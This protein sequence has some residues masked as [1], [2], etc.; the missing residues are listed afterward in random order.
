MKW[1]QIAIIVIISASVALFIQKMIAPEA[2]VATGLQ[3]TAL[4]RITKNGVLRCGYIP[5]KPMA[6][7]DPATGAMSGFA[8]DFMNE[9][10][11]KSNLKI[12]WTTELTHT[13]WFQAIKGG[14]IDA[15][16]T[17]IWPHVSLYKEIKFTRPLMWDDL[18]PV[19]RASDPRFDGSNISIDTNVLTIAVKQ[20]DSTAQ[21][22][23]TVLPKAKFAIYAMETT[24]DALYKLLMDREFDVVLRDRNSANQFAQQNLGTVRILLDKGNIGRIAYEMAVDIK[25]TELVDLFNRF[26]K[27][28]QGNKGIEQLLNKWYG[29][30]GVPSY[31]PGPM[32]LEPYFPFTVLDVGLPKPW[33][34][35]QSK[36]Q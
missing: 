35:D 6:M 14:Q 26:I 3:D 12:E 15:L 21:L 20:G 34:R 7:K 36:P 27:D 29:E 31:I 16:C 33:R 11:A 23:K 8:V 5:S 24:D 17:P 13:S 18:Y 10:G 30:T 2:I 25:E 32:E 28:M 19:V 4:E 22:A 9:L 1:A